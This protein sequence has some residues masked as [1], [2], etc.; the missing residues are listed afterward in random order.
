MGFFHTQLVVQRQWEYYFSKVWGHL[1][2]NPIFHHPRQTIINILIHM[3]CKCFLKSPELFLFCVTSAQSNVD[4]PI[5]GHVNV[6]SDY[7][8]TGPEKNF[9]TQSLQSCH[10]YA[11]QISSK[12]T[13]LGLLKCMHV[14]CPSILTKLSTLMGWTRKSN[15]ALTPNRN[16]DF[17]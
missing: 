10:W 16:S 8:E 14:F 11:D 3:R 6:L 17:C 4:F 1:N 12:K 9:L 5:G 7:K 13:Y 2:H 15:C